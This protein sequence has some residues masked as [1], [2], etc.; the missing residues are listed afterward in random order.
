MIKKLKIG[1]LRAK[2]LRKNVFI[3]LGGGST[4]CPPALPLVRVVLLHK[5]AF[6]QSFLSRSVYLAWWLCGKASW[7][8]YIWFWCIDNV[9]L[10]IVCEKNAKLEVIVQ[11]IIQTTSY[12]FLCNTNI[13]TTHALRI[14][15]LSVLKYISRTKVINIL[16]INWTIKQIVR[17]P[18]Y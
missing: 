8:M 2:D 11:N 14:I 10:W 18:K 9:K 13:A 16:Y 15:L 4:P 1:T 12:I 17:S 6:V 5:W 3:F 7:N